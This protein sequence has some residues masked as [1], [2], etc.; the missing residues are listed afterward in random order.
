MIRTPGLTSDFASIFSKACLIGISSLILALSINAT[1]HADPWRVSGFDL[2]ADIEKRV[3]DQI[4]DIKTADDLQTIMTKIGRFI[5]LSRMDAYKE[6]GTWVITGNRLPVIR[7]IKTDLALSFL[8][9]QV[10]VATRDFIDQAD[11]SQTELQITNAIGA[12]LARKG[13]P[14]VK[15]NY[16]RSTDANESVLTAMISLGPICLIKETVLHFRLPQGYF[17]SLDNDQVCDL[18][19]IQEKLDELQT[20]LI[21]DGY[22]Q[23]RIE[24][25]KLQI[26]DDSLTA[27]MDIFGQAGNLVQYKIL[28]DQKETDLEDIFAEEDLSRIDPQFV[29]PDAMAGELERVFQL[30][31]FADVQVQGPKLGKSKSSESIYIYEVS[32][33]PKYSLNLI[34]FEGNSVFSESELVDIMG[35]SGVFSTAAVYDLDGMRQALDS[36]RGAYGARGYWDASTSDPRITK[37]RDFGR[38]Q[39][40]IT[41]QEG[42]QRV[43]RDFVVNGA[44]VI[45]PESIRGMLSPEKGQP[46]DRNQLIEMEKQIRARY[47]EM[48]FLYVDLRTE[49][50]ASSEDQMIQTDV[51]VDIIENRRVKIGLIRIHGLVKT[52]PKVITR[53]LEF[54]SGDW[55]VPD[56]IDASRRA[57]INLGLFRSVQI[58]PADL[59]SIDD[60]DEILDLIIT[61]RES[62][63]GT[64]SFG[65]GWSL[66]RGQRF[67]IE[68]SYNNVGGVGRQIYARGKISEE[69]NQEAIGD[70]TLLGRSISLGYLEP[71]VLGLPVDGSASVSAKAEAGEYWS[72]ARSGEVSLTHRF[73][74][75]FLRGSSLS[76]FYG[77]KISEVF[78]SPRQDEAEDAPSQIRVGQ[79]GIR[80]RMDRRNQV[81]WPSSGY[82]LRTET[83]WARFPLGGDLQYFF[84]EIENNYFFLLRRNWVLALGG[85]FASFNSVET[86]GSDSIRTLPLN[87]RL[88]IEGPTTVRGF[89]ENSLGPIIVYAPDE[90]GSSR[91][92]TL[93]KGSQL[94]VFHL[95][96]RRQIVTDTFAA[97]AFID[98]G[99]VFF[100]QEEEQYFDTP[101]ATLVD[102]APYEF[103]DLLSNPDYLWTR[104][105]TS[106]GL[107]LNY[108]TPIGSLNLAYGLPWNRCAGRFGTC[109]K[110]RG[111]KSD[112]QILTGQFHIN[113][114]ATF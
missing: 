84:Y 92:D 46:L 9:T 17:L 5:K 39:A 44:T 102:N 76:L 65:P 78:L 60:K 67:G 75:A 34:E 80:F 30:Q 114:G 57:L 70:S 106:W 7:N 1:A 53:E 68:A 22:K 85:S 63:P 52:E 42:K 12:A 81:S 101:G 38:A 61:V 58:A 96:L 103:L 89:Q 73:R 2:P 98:S 16:M 82:F 49:V 15:I 10:E 47:I 33:G 87:E 50:R 64:I 21:Q 40:V 43:L 91:D 3:R 20:R 35:L 112:W 31:G 14:R 48:G 69:S 110:A 27:R 83:S 37:D 51:I 95:E 13:F 32:S 94:A 105:Y 109:V 11:D 108:L 97:A 90:T 62:N 54:E 72:I 71:Y 8:R 111:K 93:A 23:A 45:S 66:D 77:Q 25:P 74:G 19:K 113:V 99:N 59:R 88:S 4:S 24:A 36:I 18:D 55:Y 104:N 26:D 79:V 56:Q 86:R 41:I 6:G 29:G 100:T 28:V 107:A